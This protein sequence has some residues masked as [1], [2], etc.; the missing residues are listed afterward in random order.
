MQIQIIKIF[1]LCAAAKAGLS[2]KFAVL[3]AYIRKKKNLK[4][5]A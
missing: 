1:I 4:P 3:N 5:I 2:G